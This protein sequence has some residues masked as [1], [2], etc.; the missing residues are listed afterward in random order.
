MRK[1][2]PAPVLAEWTRPPHRL[3]APLNLRASSMMSN[4][5]PGG[6][7]MEAAVRHRIPGIV[8]ECGRA[9][10]CISDVT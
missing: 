6:M 7:V 8:A 3:Q 10:A 9:C 5:I 2:K 4:V 1:S